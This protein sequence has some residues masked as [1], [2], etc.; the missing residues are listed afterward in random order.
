MKCPL[1]EFGYYSAASEGS[2]L[3]QTSASPEFSDLQN[4]GLTFALTGM[5]VQSMAWFWPHGHPGWPGLST[6]VPPPSPALAEGIA[7]YLLWS[8]TSLFAGSTGTLRKGSQDLHICGRTAH[9]LGRRTF[10]NCPWEPPRILRILPALLLKHS[11]RPPSCGEDQAGPVGTVIESPQFCRWFH[12]PLSLSRASIHRSN[13]TPPCLERR[14]RKQWC[15][16]LS[17]HS[18]QT[19]YCNS[20]HTKNM[21]HWYNFFYVCVK[22]CFNQV[23]W[24][25][26]M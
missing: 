2:V 17:S 15:S 22:Q 11:G 7:L 14:T 3:H 25:I 24:E 6:P 10:P 16:T 19:N 12:P 8:I 20:E 26:A 9:T 1:K 18:T 13:C 4:I 5:C 23:V 21:L